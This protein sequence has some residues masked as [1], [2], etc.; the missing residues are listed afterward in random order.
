MNRLLIAV[1]VVSFN[2][3]DAN[4]ELSSLVNDNSWK[5][6]IIGNFNNAPNSITFNKYSTDVP[7]ANSKEN[8]DVISGLFQNQK[9]EEWLDKINFGNSGFDTKKCIDITNSAYLSQQLKIV[10]S[11]EK[12]KDKSSKLSTGAIIGIVVGCVAFVAIIV[13][14]VVVVVRKK[15]V[16]VQA[17]SSENN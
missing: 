10:L 1:Q 13:V 4:L 12:S 6:F 5:P 15:K 11:K 3:V 7:D 9:C 2:N 14:V 17:S 16:K 8:F